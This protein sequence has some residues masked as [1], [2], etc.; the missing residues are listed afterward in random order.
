MSDKPGLTQ[1]QGAAVMLGFL[2]FIANMANLL[3]KGPPSPLMSE[4]GNK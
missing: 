2:L 4:K 1:E 3:A